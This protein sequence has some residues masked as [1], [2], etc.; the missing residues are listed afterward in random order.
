VKKKPIKLAMPKWG[1]FALVGVGALVA[2]LAGWTILLGPKQHTIGSLRS[3]TSAVQQQIAADLSRAADARNGSGAPTIKVAD[4][5]KLQTAMPSATDM[6]DLLLELNQTAKAAGVQLQSIQPS[7]PAAGSST[8]P[9]TTV[10]ISLTA[11]GNFYSLTDLL[12]RLRNLVYVSSGALEANGRIFDVN[13]VSLSTQS[14]VV[15][16]EI[17]LDTYVYGGGTSS[18]VAPTTAP[19]DTTDTTTTTSDSSSGPTAAGTTP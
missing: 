1:P 10:P 7:T 18:A 2:V 15:T 11:T 16:A 8:G 6:P 19:T 9:Y 4:I 3:Q 17:S 12:Y 13:S 14:G 5:Y